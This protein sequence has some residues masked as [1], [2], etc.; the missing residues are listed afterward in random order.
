MKIKNINI[1][2]ST[3]SVGRNVLEVVR[4]YPDRFRITGLSANENTS[5]LADQAEEFSPRA[6]VVS[7]EKSCSDITG[8]HRSDTE[9]LVGEEGLEELASDRT[10]D[11]VFV[12]ISGV[13]ALKPL[14]AALK[15]GRTVA[16]A[17]KEPVVSAGSLIMKLQEESSSRVIPVDSE[18]SAIMQCLQGRSTREVRTLYITGSGGSLRNTSRERFDSLTVGEVLDHPKWDMGRKITVDSATLMNKGLEVIEARWLFDMA[19]EKIRVVIHPEAVIHSM[20]EFNDGTVTAGMFCPDMRFPILKAMSY[21]D[22]LESDFPRIDFTELNKLTFLEPDTGKYPALEL[23]YSVLK[24]GGVMPAVLN[25]ANEAAVKLFLEGKLKFTG[26][27]D[28]VRQILSKCKNIIDPT[29]ED[30][31]DSEKWAMEE[32][33]RS[34]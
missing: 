5:L 10:A 1:L 21:P 6:V 17:S 12:A 8:R 22:I 9:I 20:V 33:L 30:I 25:G 24:E 29:L 13:A 16:L 11:M 19:P 23:A 3:G 7:S 18:H 15:A 2:G 26:I 31:I 14:M 32:V 34:C 27:T 28:T 4:S